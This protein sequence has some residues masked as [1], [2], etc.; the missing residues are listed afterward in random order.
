MESVPTA[1]AIVKMDLQDNRVNLP[2]IRVPGR[3]AARMGF[4]T[5]GTAFARTGTP[6][7][8]AKTPLCWIPVAGLLTPAKNVWA[9]KS[10]SGISDRLLVTIR[11]ESYVVLRLLEQTLPS[12][13]DMARNSS[14]EN[15]T[16]V[17]FGEQTTIIAGWRGTTTYRINGKDNLSMLQNVILRR[18][19]LA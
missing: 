6:E 1:C 16:I 2:Q 7:H 10:I 14:K 12:H 8:F 3:I 5:K 11:V 19:V 18:L 13:K 4:V 9:I 17:V 15:P